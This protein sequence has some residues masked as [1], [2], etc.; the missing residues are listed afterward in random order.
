[1]SA[2]FPFTLRFWPLQWAGWL[3]LA[4]ASLPLK[5]YFYSDLGTVLE[6]T[7]AREGFGF[8]F[9]WGV[10]TLWR[11]NG[12]KID[13]RPGRQV[14]LVLGFAILGAVAD[15]VL[16]AGN[17]RWVEPERVR[18]FQIVSGCYRAL[19]LAIWGLLYFGLKAVRARQQMAL[20]MRDAELA[21]LR[22]QLSP[23]FLFNALNTLQACALRAPEEVSPLIQNLAGTLR[24]TLKHREAAFVPL[25]EE[26]AALEDYLAIEQARFRGDLVVTLA[27]AAQA[28]ECPVPGLAVQP[29][30][31]NALKHGRATSEHPLRVRIEI[32]RPT[33]GEVRVE[34][35]NTGRWR[36]PAPA[37]EGF[38]IGLA[39][40]RHRLELAYGKRATLTQ[41]EAD[42]W[43]CM[44][45]CL[46]ITPP[47]ARTNH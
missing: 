15:G 9:T 30:V 28:R 26:V 12:A 2:P 25:R 34:V 6:V 40:L 35:A 39:N 38:G 1:M 32:T 31:E 11:A 13:H 3:G 17:A 21:L 7:L 36:P 18:D 23:H 22:S 19:V 24:Y 37:G 5:L 33:A 20:A 29:L 42:G 16:M 8:L 41:S 47:H 10:R 46:P 45:L 44:V 27:L 4:V 43:V 14:A